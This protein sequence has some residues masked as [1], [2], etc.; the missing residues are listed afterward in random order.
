MTAE[1]IATLDQAMDDAGVRHTSEVYEGAQ[2]GYTMSDMGAHNE[3]AAERYFDA[4][5][6]VLQRTIPR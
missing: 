4:L 2:R 3:A 1:N 5:F 6:A